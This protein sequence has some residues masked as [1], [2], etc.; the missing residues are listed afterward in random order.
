MTKI[1]SPSNVWGTGMQKPCGLPV[2]SVN[3]RW[4]GILHTVIPG[5]HRVRRQMRPSRSSR[6]KAGRLGPDY[7]LPTGVLPIINIRWI[8]PF[9]TYPC[10]AVST[11]HLIFHTPVHWHVDKIINL[12]CASISRES[13]W[14]KD[15]G[16]QDQR[17]HD[18]CTG[19][20]SGASLPRN[21]G[22]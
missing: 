15:D 10:P 5:L 6:D 1:V 22:E 20:C 9:G 17:W 11:W 14:Y 21:S 3:V 13:G 19:V 12:I 16:V 7:R 18:R 2:F 8:Q 4:K